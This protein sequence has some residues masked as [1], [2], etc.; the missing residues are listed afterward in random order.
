VAA[1]NILTQ[2]GAGGRK[3]GTGGRKFRIVFIPH[4][5]KNSTRQPQQG[6]GETKQTKQTEK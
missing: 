4:K 6:T 5:E 3:S 1:A 2:S